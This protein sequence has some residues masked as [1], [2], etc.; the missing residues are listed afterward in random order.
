MQC[1]LLYYVSVNALLEILFLLFST[2]SIL[3]V[4]LMLSLFYVTG[5][6]YNC[7]DPYNSF[8]SLL[9]SKSFS[10]ITI[11]KLSNLVF[12]ISLDQFNRVVYFCSN[13]VAGLF[14]PVLKSSAATNTN[15][16][17][18]CVPLLI[19]YP[20]FLILSFLFK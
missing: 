10:I 7:L 18:V 12:K 17:T 8:L 14:F 19:I 4:Y 1:L 2:D 6:I 11:L 9:M 15:G 5:D 13:C 20:G 3:L 16:Y